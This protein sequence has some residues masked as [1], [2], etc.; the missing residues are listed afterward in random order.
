M[1]KYELS[2]STDYV[3]N[4]GITEAIRELFQNS[5]D[6]QSQNPS[7]VMSHNYF[8]DYGTFRISSKESVLDPASLLLGYSTKR[9]DS[10]LIGQFGEGYKLAILVLLRNGKQVK[11][12][13]YGKREIW[14][15]KFVKSRKY[16]DQKILV[17]E[18]DKK[19]IWEKVPSN[20]LTFEIKGITEEE[21]QDI[22][23]KNLHCQNDLGET[24]ITPKGK[25]LLD[26]PYKGK[27]YVNGL[28]VCKFDHYKYG[29]DIL[30]NYIKL[31]RDRK[32]VSDFD[33]KWLASTMWVSSGS[34][35]MVEL[36]KENASD[37]FYLSETWKINNT[38]S[39]NAFNEFIAK[40]GPNAIPVVSQDE[41]ENI[42]KL[43][44]LANP[45]YVSGSYYGIISSSGL[46]SDYMD[47]KQVAF[48]SDKDK[49][50]AW[51][52]KVKIRLFHSDEE[53]FEDLYK[54]LFKENTN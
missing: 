43:H 38:L 49:L 11:I 10:N 42:K 47:K 3:S 41:A 20:N 44:P 45:I 26:P 1:S 23:D 27:I 25:I 39:N 16:N 4:W 51:Y 30:P 36:A 9:N 24:I 2:L 5:L 12:Y 48:L 31:D 17:I 7:N 14:Y 29:Y 37:V 28:F 50:W 6:Q 32:L 34:V 8:I 33:L 18:I 15:P 54:K 40:Y 35:K 13:N 19:H 46:Y 22:I 21:Y 52:L 53:E